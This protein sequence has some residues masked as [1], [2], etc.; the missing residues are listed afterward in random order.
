MTGTE[1][2]HQPDPAA[3]E[4]ERAAAEVGRMVRQA[5]AQERFRAPAWRQR[6]APRRPPRAATLGWLAAAGAVVVAVGVARTR[7]PNPAPALKYVVS[8]ALSETAERAWGAQEQPATVRFSDGTRLALEPG[9]RARLES[10]AA[11]GAHVRVTDGR[12]RFVVAKRPGARWSVAVGAFVVQ[13]TGTVFTVSAGRDRHLSEVRVDEGH[14]IVRPATDPASAPGLAVGAG[15][16]AIGDNDTGRVWLESSV[17]LPGA[18]K[19]PPPT[20]SAPPPQPGA[21]RGDANARSRRWAQWI[22]A[23]D[24]GAVLADAERVRG[25]LARCT[26]D[27]LYSWASAAH[28]ARRET[29][30]RAA[31]Q[32]LRRRFP[33][34]AAAVEAAFF[35]GRSYEDEARPD[36]ALTWYARYLAEAPAGAYAGSA[37]ARRMLIFDQRGD[38]TAAQA[39]ARGYLSR[40]P[41]GPYAPQAAALCR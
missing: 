21:A 3:R 12:A 38:R 26:R 33:S 7:G 27:E 6:V 5:I 1:T 25:C 8:P 23:G 2:P 31:H 37:L 30:A 10:I 24:Y 41:G 13:V 14:V 4:A 16:V 36:E 22:A 19:A 20:A 34:T 40:F 9:S 28:Y 29:V 32:A 18:P 15:Q 39:A 17:A 35:L 11:D